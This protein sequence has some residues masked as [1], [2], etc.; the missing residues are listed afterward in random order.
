[1]PGL[2]IALFLSA[3]LLLAYALFPRTQPVGRKH[4][5]A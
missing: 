3:L 4:D 5:H 2:G 1:V